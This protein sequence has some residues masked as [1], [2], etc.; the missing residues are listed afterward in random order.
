MERSLAN[1]V[2]LVTA[3]KGRTRHYLPTMITLTDNTELCFFAVC[4]VSVLYTIYQLPR[5]VTWVCFVVWCWW[6]GV[7]QVSAQQE[8]MGA[9]LAFYADEE[10]PLDL[11]A[12]SELCEDDV[13]RSTRRVRR[14]RKAPFAAWLVEEIRGAHLSQCSRTDAN[15]L[16][17]ERYARSIMAEHNVRPSDAAKVLP[18]ATIL[19]FEHRS[20]D[21]IAAVGTTQS[22]AFVS[23]RRDFAAKYV[24]RSGWFSFGNAS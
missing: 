1:A 11:D 22:S 14:S 10:D 21:Q 6:N 15:V 3:T 8:R 24:G 7:V 19:F 2:Q 9:R 13:G 20:F 5:F 4:I 16:I 17:F 18:Y 12:V 23:A